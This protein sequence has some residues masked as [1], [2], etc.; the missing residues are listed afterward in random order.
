MKYP[1]FTRDR[2]FYKTLLILAIPIA[3]QNFISYG[4]NFLDNIMIGK[5][6]E[7]D[8]AGVYIGNQFYTVVSLLESGVTG[9]LVILGAQ[10]WGRKDAGSIRNLTSLSIKCALVLGTLFALLGTFCPK[11]ILSL[12]SEDAVVVDSGVRYLK[13]VCWSYIF[14]CYSQTLIA[15]MQ[16]VEDVRFASYPRYFCAYWAYGPAVKTLY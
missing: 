11:P 4:V 8:I 9:A 7:I 16:S 10:Y 3:L 14:F 2:S 5:L 1:L 13:T 12:F 15:S 6:G